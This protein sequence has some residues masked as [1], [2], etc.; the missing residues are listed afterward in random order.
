MTSARKM[1]R[2]ENNCTEVVHE[3]FTNAACPAVSV[4]RNCSSRE[5]L[6]EADFEARTLRKKKSDA[7]RRKLHN[8]CARGIYKRLLTPL[9]INMDLIFTEVSRQVWRQER[10]EEK[11]K[12]KE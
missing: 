12:H 3:A 4:A 2:N 1:A 6:L 5:A 10:G 8:I 11:K 9:N 7:K